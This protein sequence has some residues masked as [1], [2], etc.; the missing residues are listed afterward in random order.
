MEAVIVSADSTNGMVAQIKMGTHYFEI[1]ESTSEENKQT[2]PAPNDYILS[3]LG[4][5]TVITLHM[6]AKRKGWPLER[7]EVQLQQVPLQTGTDIQVGQN[8]NKRL[9]ITKRL[10]LTGNLTSE[11]VKRLE[12][13]SSRCP[14]Q[15]TLEAGVVIQTILE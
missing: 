2:Q 14:V 1:D 6:Y 11:Q 15:R 4:A 13:I 9:L 8:N 12:D 3:A 10:K 5:C 7:A